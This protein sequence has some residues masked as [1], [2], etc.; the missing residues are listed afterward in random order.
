MPT[1]PTFYTILVQFLILSG[2]LSCI[3]VLLGLIFQKSDVQIM[4]D[5]RED[6][7]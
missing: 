1:S 2:A 3:F 7:F 5:V 4:K 6:G